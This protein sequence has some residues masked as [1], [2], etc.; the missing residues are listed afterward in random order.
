MS[1]KDGKRLVVSL[2]SRDVKIL[3]EETQKE[4]VSEGTIVRNALRLYSAIREL[5]D[6]PLKIKTKDGKMVTILV[7]S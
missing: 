7:V 6:G 3:K 5:S 4:G 2:T 1:R